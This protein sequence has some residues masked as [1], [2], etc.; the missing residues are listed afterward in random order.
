MLHAK[1]VADL[2]LHTVFSYDGKSLAEEYVLAA[3][4]AGDKRIGFSEHYDYDS[5]IS[6][7]STGSPPCDLYAYKTEIERLRDKYGEK[8]EIHFGVEF[9]YDKRACEKYAEL[10]EKFSFDYVINSVHLFRG[11]DFW[12]TDKI[13]QYSIPAKDIYKYYLDTVVE[14]VFASYPFDIIGHL[15]YPLRYSPCKEHNFSYDDF[16]GDYETI[17]QAIVKNGKCLEIN[18]ST[19]TDKLFNPDEKIIER[20][21]ALGGK[22]VSFGSDAHYLCRYADKKTSVTETAKKFGLKFFCGKNGEFIE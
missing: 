12:L 4:A 10:T 13:L 14:S 3:V 17:L 18:T 22:K 21:A 1:E 20:Y 2:H 8:T 15:G 11:T 19:K 6:G 5:A 9:G 16:A 7:T